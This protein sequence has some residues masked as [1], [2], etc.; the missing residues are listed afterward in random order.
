MADCIPAIS[1][2]VPA[3]FFIIFAVPSKIGCTGFVTIFAVSAVHFIAHLY[4]VPTSFGFI[5]VITSSGFSTTN[6]VAPSSTLFVAFNIPCPHHFLPSA[7][8]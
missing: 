1:S 2:G 7:S 6:F 8:L 3:Y 4:I 5:M